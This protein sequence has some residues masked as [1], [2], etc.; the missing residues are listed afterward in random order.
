MRS[1]RSDRSASSVQARVLQLAT[2]RQGRRHAKTDK[3]TAR[4]ITF[5]VQVATLA[6]HPQARRAG[7]QRIETIARQTH[8]C[9]QQT[10]EGDLHW[11]RAPRGINELRQK[12]QEEQRRLRIQNIDDE[13]V[14][15]QLT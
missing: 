5:P 12:R 8:Q 13:T 15:I 10:E 14:A 1:P 11:D 4:D 9:K 7:D 3:Y 6:L 2:T